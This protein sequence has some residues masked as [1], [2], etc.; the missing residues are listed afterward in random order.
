[1]K[2]NKNLNLFAFASILAIFLL[3]LPDH[4]S[5]AVLATRSEVKDSPEGE[6]TLVLDR[7]TGVEILETIKDWTKIRFRVSNPKGTVADGFIKPNSNLY[8][9]AQDFNW[10]KKYGSIGKTIKKVKIAIFPFQPSAKISG[11]IVGYV[12]KNNLTTPIVEKTERLSKLKS[13][14]Y[15]RS[16]FV[17][18]KTKTYDVGAAWDQHPV[19][20]DF[21]ASDGQ[22]VVFTGGDYREMLVEFTIDVK[23]NIK[24][25]TCFDTFCIEKFTI[26]GPKRFSIMVSGIKQTFVS[27][28][29]MKEYS[30]K[31]NDD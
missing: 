4:I 20:C 17:D 27:T 16:D 14:Y 30:D 26:E 19:F 22:T 13:G 25:E 3:S 21:Q 18:F 9:F 6:T 1:M 24:G 23:G 12:N 7:G 11:Y 10:D 2:T 5:A 8:I 15:F 28:E 29:N 31:Q